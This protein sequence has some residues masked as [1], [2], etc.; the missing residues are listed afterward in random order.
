MKLSFTLKM[1]LLSV[2][3]WLPLETAW[4][5]LYLTPQVRPRAEWR[6]GYQSLPNGQDGAFFVSQR[7]RITL[8]YKQD[9]VQTRFSLQDVRVWGDEAHLKDVPSTAMH[10]AWGELALSDKFAVRLGRQEFVYNNDRLLGNVDWVQ[11]ARSHDGLLLKARWQGISVDAGGAFNQEKEA[12]FDTHYSMNNYKVLGFLWAQKQLG[13]QLSVSAMHISDGFQ[14]PDTVGGVYFRHTYG[15]DLTYQRERLQFNGSLYRQ[16]G[17][18]GSGKKI[19]AYLAVAEA[20]YTYQPFRF[21]LGTT[22]LS[23]MAGQERKVHSFNTLYATNH[24]YYG[25]MDYFINVPADTRQGGL[26]NTYLKTTFSPKPRYSISLD[27]HYFALAKNLHASETHAGTNNRYLGS[28]LDAVL[29]YKHSDQIQFSVGYSNLFAGRSMAAIKPGD[30]SAYADW[31]WVM[32]NIQPRIL[33][34]S[35]EKE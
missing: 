29:Q 35:F 8:D 5:Q 18:H 1:L 33:L 2:L 19:A 17:E 10:E 3:V 27:Y 23:G 34:K 9:K 31:G 30:A 26:L 28:E 14:R 13:D 12:L 21:T 32:V 6:N 25:F 7:S 15:L 4:A 22:Y 11:Q 20:A 16:S 24:K